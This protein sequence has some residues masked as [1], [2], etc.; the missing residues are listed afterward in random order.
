MYFD[1]ASCSIR[2][3][4]LRPKFIKTEAEDFV[5]LKDIHRLGQSV[6]II[7]SQKALRKIPHNL[8][9]ASLRDLKGTRVV[10]EDGKHLGKL[11]DVHVFTETG[12]ISEINFYDQKTLK[13]M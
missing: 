12:I 3:L 7:S 5:D 6:V 8:W 13:S 2:G 1:K 4:S 9:G 10:T 11:Q